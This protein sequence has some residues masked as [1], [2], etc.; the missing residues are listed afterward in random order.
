ME[1]TSSICTS[2]S[3]ILIVVLIVLIVVVWPETGGAAEIYNTIEEINF[4]DKLLPNQGSTSNDELLPRSKDLVRT[5]PQTQGPIYR[6]ATESALK[7]VLH[8]CIVVSYTISYVILR[9]HQARLLDRLISSQ[10]AVFF[11]RKNSAINTS[12]AKS[13]TSPKLIF[14]SACKRRRRVIFRPRHGRRVYD[15]VN[16]Y[17]TLGFLTSWGTYPVVG[18][19]VKKINPVGRFFFCRVL[20]DIF[21]KHGVFFFSFEVFL[22]FC[23]GRREGIGP[24]FPSEWTLCH[25]HSE[26]YHHAICSLLRGRSC[27]ISRS[28]WSLI[29]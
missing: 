4:Q 19:F 24:D 22:G 14:V 3:S 8:K 15:R 18:G 21:F 23:P 9:T 27:K 16:D 1:C 11:E 25:L 6:S 13:I 10:I 12:T 17:P 26:S 28:F 5:F 29:V 2:W 20:C 7:F